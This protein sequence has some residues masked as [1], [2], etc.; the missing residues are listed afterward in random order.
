MTNRRVYG[1]AVAHSFGLTE[2]PRLVTRALR[3]AQIVISRLSLGA[4]QKRAVVAHSAGG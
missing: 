2:T 4:A 1:D 3:S